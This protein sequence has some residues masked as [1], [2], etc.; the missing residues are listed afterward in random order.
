MKILFGFFISFIAC[1]FVQC[2][3]SS[4]RK[5]NMLS[6]YI[7]YIEKSDLATLC[8]QNFVDA[9]VKYDSGKCDM[10]MFCSL[11]LKKEFLNGKYS[12]GEVT[13]YKSKYDFG[14][15]MEAGEIFYVISLSSVKRDTAYFWVKEGGMR[16][17]SML[18][19]GKIVYW[20]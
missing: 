8:Q 2:D 20:L 13:A 18:R 11:Y 16:S 7:Y 3:S 15:L 10:L 12:Y 6:S 19:K 1:L 14:E 5:L 4:K 17:A 9:S